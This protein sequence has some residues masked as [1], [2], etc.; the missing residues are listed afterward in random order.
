MLPDVAV[1]HSPYPVHRAETGEQFVSILGAVARRSL[2]VD[3]I[4][5]ICVVGLSGLTFGGRF[6][7]LYGTHSRPGT[8]GQAA[9]DSTIGL[10]LG[11]YGDTSK[12]VM[13]VK[14]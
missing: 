9:A 10:R 6:L 11:Q 3:C 13:G 1:F 8:Q 4:F 7:P 2:P 12:T 14:E 5:V